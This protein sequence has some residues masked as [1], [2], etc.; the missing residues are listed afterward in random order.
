MVPGLCVA[1]FS[2]R[3]EFLLKTNSAYPRKRG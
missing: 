3:V 2:L 1:L